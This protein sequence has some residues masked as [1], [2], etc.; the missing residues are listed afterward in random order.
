MPS[1]KPSLAVDVM[2]D[3]QLWDLGWKLLCHIDRDQYPGLLGRSDRQREI[4]Q[5][6]LIYSELNLRGTQ[7]HFVP[8]PCA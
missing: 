2:T 5:L 6:M 3:R 4:T 7:L 8:V 1:R